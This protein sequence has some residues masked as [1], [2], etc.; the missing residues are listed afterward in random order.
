[1]TETPTSAPRIFHLLLGFGLVAAA[2][3]LDL[4]LGQP[5]GWGNL[6]LLGIGAGLG[7]AATAWLLPAGLRRATVGLCLSGLMALLVVYAIE[8]GAR[9]VG[10]DFS[11]AEQSYLRLPP[12]YRQPRVPVGEAFFRR[13]GPQQWQGQVLNEFIEQVGIAPNPYGDEQPVVVDYDAQGFRNPPDLDDWEVVVLGDSFTELG[14]LKH[15]DLFT[16]QLSQG[17]GVTVKNLGVSQ[18][19]SLSQATYFE[20]YGFAPSTKH[21]VVVFFVNDL[22]ESKLEL[23]G[24]RRLQ[25]TGVRDLRLGE[26]QTSAF[27][28]VRSFIRQEPAVVK[29]VDHATFGPE[30]IPVSA[31]F[32]PLHPDDLEPQMRASVDE[33]LNLGLSKIARLARERGITPWLV[34]MPCKARVHFGQLE[35]TERVLDHV[36]NWTPSRLP[37]YVAEQCA[38]NGLRFLDLSPILTADAQDSGELL[39]NSIYDMHLNRR[40]SRIVGETLIDLLRE[41]WDLPPL[42]PA[43]LGGPQAK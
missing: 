4:V 13:R 14:Y 27:Q 42:L 3:S 26:K 19:A 1:M 33:S 39:Y 31:Y 10:H 11:G 15:A 17:L 34:Y 9:L 37:E 7:I 18:T 29:R 32:A 25:E 43:Q 35:F 5:L 36:A 24:L 23:E 40:G 8:A 22:L 2:A 28:A 12:Y 21:V 16:T 30:R 38:A 6:E 41:G 20:E